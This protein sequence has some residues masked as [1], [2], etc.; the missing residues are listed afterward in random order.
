MLGRLIIL[1]IVVPL[2]DL[3]LLMALADKTGWQTSVA[4]VIV[5]GIIGAYLAKRSSQAVWDKI[6]QRFS[7]GEFAA[8]LLSDG[9]MIFFA[10]GLLLTPGFITDAVGLSILIPPIRGF[11]KRKIVKW[12]KLKANFQV[13]MP[14][15]RPPEDDFSGDP[16]TVEGEVVIDEERP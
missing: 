1:F 9:A 6:R 5:S 14:T 13:V 4:L 15:A 11:Y 3:W 7:Q 8:D 16:N 12:F 2:A 10:S